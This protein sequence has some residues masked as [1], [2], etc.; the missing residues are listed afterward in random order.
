MVIF[1][2]LHLHYFKKPI[3]NVFNQLIYSLIKIYLS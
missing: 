1:I 2:N 3:N